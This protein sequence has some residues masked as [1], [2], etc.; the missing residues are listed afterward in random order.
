MTVGDVPFE[1]FFVGG[2][3]LNNFTLDGR[4]IVQLR[5]Y[6]NP[7]SLTAIDPVTGQQEGALIYNK[8][9]MELSYPLTLKPS[10]SIYGLAFLEAGNSFNN[11]FQEFNPFELKRSAR[12]GAAYFYACVWIIGNRL[13]LWFR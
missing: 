7:I 11:T 3:G 12:C 8:F 6:E 9:S 2:D 13:W 4:D 1:R 10:A 5:G